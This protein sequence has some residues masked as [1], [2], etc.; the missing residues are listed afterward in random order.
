VIRLPA[1]IYAGLTAIALS[2]AGIL[3]LT[4][5]PDRT[6]GLMFEAD[7]DLTDAIRYFE[8]WNAK[9]PTDYEARWHTAELLL[10]TAQPTEAARRLERMAEEWPEDARIL[11]QLAEVADCTLDLEGKLRWTEALAKLH[12][13]DAGVLAKLINLYRWFDRQEDLIRVLER[14]LILKSTPEE[15]Q[16]LTELLVAK[17]RF[18]EISAYYG[19]YAAEHPSAVE[20]H[21]AMYQAHLQNDAPKEALEELKLITQLQGTEEGDAGERSEAIE[22]ADRLLEVRAKELAASGGMDA[23]VKLYRVRIAQNPTSVE[24]RL[25]LAELYGERADEIAA[26]ELSEVVRLA[27]GSPAAWKTLARRLSWTGKT[28]EAADAFSRAVQLSPDDAPLRRALAQQLGWANRRKEAVAQY[29]WL[30]SKGRLR[31]ADRAAMAE[32]LSDMG[33]AKEALA[34]ARELVAK[35]P[36]AKSYKLLAHA[37]IASSR[38]SEVI[39]ELKE[40]TDRFS[41]DSEMWSLFGLCAKKSGLHDE[42]IRAL[43]RASKLH[44]A[45]R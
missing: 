9:H 37:A 33:D 32:L 16:E 44:G 1:R 11:S 21:L 15:H 31:I 17:K 45:Q 18:G 38:C 8:R 34:A 5:P 35:Q 26:N 30:E 12:P 40:A 39:A 41:D 19:Q 42:A 24:L 10:K 36:K 7:D 14:H 43:E 3:A 27:P 23:A 6:L 29:R 2:G 22:L 25:K 20:P 28:K 4:Y 13:N